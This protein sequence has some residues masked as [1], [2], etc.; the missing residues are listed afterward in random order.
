LDFNDKPVKVSKM[1][2]ILN[3]DKAIVS[4]EKLVK[5]SLDVNHEVGK[6]KALLFQSVFGI[7][8]QDA[9]CLSKSLCIA[10]PNGKFVKESLSDWGRK[11]TLDLEIIGKNGNTGIVRTV[12]QYDIGSEIPRLITAYVNRRVK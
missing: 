1:N 5:Y 7:T 12:W 9:D 6:N 2:S 8:D 3:A 4:I 11:I 10:L